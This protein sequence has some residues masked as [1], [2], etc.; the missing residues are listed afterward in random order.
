MGILSIFE[1]KEPKKLLEKGIDYYNKGK[2]QKAIEF[3]N[4]AIGSEPKNP[5][6]W[7]FK[8]N[9][10]KMLEKSKLAQDSY[11]KA[12]SISPTNLEIIKNYAMLL[13]SLELFKESIE[14]L[15]N[16]S[17]PDF[18]VTEILGDAYLKTGKF[19]EALVEFDKILEK[20]QNIKTYLQKKELHSLDLENL[21]KLLI[22]M[23]KS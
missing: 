12:L 20:N 11:E 10:Y 4:K 16:V 18:K 14:I 17:E 6:A 23:K 2:Y 5:D 21:T 22:F 15:E 9:A 13:N 3:F 19:E 7:Y 8:G 1:T